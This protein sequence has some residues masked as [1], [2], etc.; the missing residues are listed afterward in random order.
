MV[1]MKKFDLHSHTLHSDGIA[2]PEEIVRAAKENG[3]DGVAITDHDTT[4]GLE[5]AIA[6][7]KKE[8][9]IVVP[10]VEITTK[11]GD[12]LAYGIKVIPTGEPLKILDSI[13]EQGGAAAIAHPCG[14]WLPLRFVDMMDVFKN[15]IDALETYNANVSME[16]NVIAMQTAKKHNIPGI[17]GSDAHVTEQVGSA[18]TEIEA[19]TVNDI[20][21]A[22]RKGKTAV[23]WK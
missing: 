18:F 8:R 20:I 6:T 17:G 19:E 16:Y 3:M 10:G 23:R 7:G 21:K 15:S 13:H 2:T 22:I 9:I 5:E 12:I 1:V 11:I 14:P 4:E